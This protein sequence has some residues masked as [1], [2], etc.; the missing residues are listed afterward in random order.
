M[1]GNKKRFFAFG[2]SFTS[3]LTATWADFIGVNFEEYY[4][5]GRAGACNTYIL[6]KFVE[7]NAVYNLNADTDY[8]V[9]MF[10]AFERFSFY[11]KIGWKLNGNLQNLDELNFFTSEM[12]SRDWGVY[13]SYISINAISTILQQKNINH[14]L[15]PAFNEYYDLTNE[16]DGLF[17]RTLS[18]QYI[19]D[20]KK[21]LDG[22]EAM[23]DWKNRNFNYPKDFYPFEEPHGIIV[24]PHPTQYMH[25]QFFKEKF[26]EFY[27]EKSQELFDYAE[28]ILVTNNSSVQGKLYNE[29][30][31]KKINRAYNSNLF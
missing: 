15:I 14:R 20:F 25:F 21:L 13:N 28:S 3:H 31:Y 6:N 18:Y 16:N 24:D 7:A 10:T 9:V 4:N 22:T 19:E 11:N 30:I 29:N 17:T 8:V 12:W 26:S 5:F 27:T 1:V 2:C 23:E